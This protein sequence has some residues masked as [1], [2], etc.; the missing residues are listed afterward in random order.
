MLITM[1]KK[2]NNI[3]KREG[4]REKNMKT[5]DLAFGIHR[6]KENNTKT[7]N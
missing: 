5:S 2:N 4:E 3:N 1:I 6:L 7:K